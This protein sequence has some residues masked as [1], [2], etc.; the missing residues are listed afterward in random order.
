[1]RPSI[2]SHLFGRFPK[3][4]R[5]RALFLLA[6]LLPLPAFAQL[7][8]S[9]SLPSPRIPL[10]APVPAIVRVTN[11]T[12]TDFTLGPGGDA[13]LTFQAEGS[14]HLPVPPPPSPRPLLKSPVTV[15][16]GTTVA[17]SV[18]VARSA[19]LANADDYFV[20]PVLAVPGFPPV[21]GKRLPLEVQPG[22]IAASRDFGVPAAGTHR[23]ATVRVIHRASAQSDIAYF[24]LDD[25]TDFAC[26][27]VYELGTII[28]YFNPQIELDSENTFHVLFQNTPER[29][30]HCTFS[31]DG[32]PLHTDVYLARA[33]E[34]TLY[35]LPDG[36]IKV[37]HG[38]LFT[39]DPSTPGF[40]S[41][42]VLPSPVPDL[43]RP[44]R[45]VERSVPARPDS[46]PAQ[47]KHFWQR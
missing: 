42:P 40:L 47:K 38:I 45:P 46:A 2:P 14:N 33:T 21:A 27:G 12:G 23:Q 31:Y 20:A 5:H 22:I 11:R 44:S 3:A 24:R 43:Q 19:L 32:V 29:F 35:R 30:F 6:L 39:P 37:A 17:L 26:Y 1:M 8:L 10:Y 13:I 4:P 9:W 41:A 25:P 36:H 18:D 28:R 7:D 34:I 16:N 15:T